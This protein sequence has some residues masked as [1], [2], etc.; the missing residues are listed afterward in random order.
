[1]A[2]I[3]VKREGYEEGTVHDYLEILMLGEKPIKKTL[4][5]YVMN[6]I[7]VS[8]AILDLEFLGSIE[9]ELKRISTSL[10]QAVDTAGVSEESSYS[11]NHEIMSLIEKIS[12]GVSSNIILG[13]N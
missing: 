7:P 13:Q 5:A 3:G 1:M 12:S 10:P 9:L 6:N 4:I 8:H 11:G 2:E